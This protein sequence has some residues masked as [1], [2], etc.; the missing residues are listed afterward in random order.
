MNRSQGSLNNSN[1][2]RGPHHN[3]HNHPIPRPTLNPRCRIYVGDLAFFCNESHLRTLF[4]QYG[5]ILDIQLMRNA[6]GQTQMHA[7]VDMQT[8]DE[9]RRAEAAL[10][11]QKL[12][13]RKIRY[14][15]M[16]Y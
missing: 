1:N 12:L 15:C 11:G 6:A 16:L 13:G 8:E 7:Y 14:R 9:A 2:R 5:T 3:P 10:D 4:S